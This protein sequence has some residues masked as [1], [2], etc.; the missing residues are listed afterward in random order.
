MG[1]IDWS[2]GQGNERQRN[3]PIPLADIPLPNQAGDDPEREGEQE[4]RQRAR[5]RHKESDTRSGDNASR[6]GADE[7]ELEGCEWFHVLAL[8]FSIHARP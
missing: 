3:G 8:R 7:Q 6:G 2:V 4:A 5:V 1:V